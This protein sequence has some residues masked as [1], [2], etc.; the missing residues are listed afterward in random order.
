[1]KIR[2]KLA[3]MVMLPLSAFVFQSAIQSTQ[4]IETIKISENMK[5]NMDAFNAVSNL[6]HELQKERGLSSVLASGEDVSG[7]LS[8]QKT[9]TDEKLGN[10]HIHVKNAA[11][12]E[13]I[14]DSAITNISSLP[15]IRKKVLPNA[16][17]A[18][19]RKKYTDIIIEIM[20]IEAAAANAPTT[21][22]I[23]KVMTSMAII[24]DSKEATGIMRA[25]L[26]SIIA[27][28]RPPSDEERNRLFNLKGIADTSLSSPALVLI[29]K[30]REKLGEFKQ[31]KDWLEVDR[32]FWMV[33]HN[34]EKN[35]Y[36]INGSDFFKVITVKIDD[37]AILL[38]TELNA[39]LDKTEKVYSSAKIEIQFTAWLTLIVFLILLIALYFISKSIRTP[40]YDAIRINSEI[41]NGDVSK[42]VPDHLLKRKDE[43]GELAVSMQKTVVS[44]RDALKGVGKWI[45]TLARSS[46]T[47]SQIS[48]KMANG[49][50][51]TSELS[52][53]VS[54]SSSE[55][56]RKSESATAKI[57]MVAE[58]ITS[59]SASIDMITGDMAETSSGAESARNI[60]VMAKEQAASIT[61]IMHGLEA[62][63]LDIGKITG[64]ISDISEQTNLLALN[65]TI[66]AARAGES[67]KG[68]AVVASEVKGLAGQTAQATQDIRLRIENVQ[69]ST[70]AATRDISKIED[71]INQ[72]NYTVSEMS[73][74]ISKQAAMLSEIAKE[75]RSVFS[76]VKEANEYALHSSNLAESQSEAISGV[77][78]AAS[79]INASSSDVNESA[80][81]LEK[82]ALQL[83]DVISGFKVTAD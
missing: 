34:L 83:Q 61:V 21:K 35:Q 39:A 1:M 2:L 80:S 36:D 65:A 23:G 70:E 71:V 75:M 13:K 81:R 37:L 79:E 48:S 54:D 20:K 45:K 19:I 62:A 5:K 11:I 57:E 74:S 4:L 3:I 76:Q 59:I 42:D 29:K 67:G 50:A 56:N 27:Q 14:K 60:T 18:E 26:S 24:E 55:M 51:R 25:M 40:I 41:A 72:V 78:C 53:A 16:D 68:F 12:D 30:S 49:A 33:A 8:N 66:E 38:H 15:E 44:L 64:T 10:F 69:K 17:A 73:V 9:L 77:S 52:M 82:L 43:I 6:I 7:V 63:V 58:S 47:L 46:T 22:G 32:V 28:K 31:K